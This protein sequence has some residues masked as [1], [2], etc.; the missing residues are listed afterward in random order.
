M[1][2]RDYSRRP[3]MA[4]LSRLYDQGVAAV[5]SGSPC[6]YRPAQAQ[7]DT[8]RENLWQN[9]FDDETDRKEVEALV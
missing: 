6:P 9:G 5:A 4:H 3:R 7:G 8:I 2:F 1:P